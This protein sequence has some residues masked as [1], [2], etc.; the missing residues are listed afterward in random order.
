[1]ARAPGEGRRGLRY[2]NILSRDFV[3]SLPKDSLLRL[4][5]DFIVAFRFR[6]EALTK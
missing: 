1:L 3:A 4:Y 5:C 6:V 2:Q